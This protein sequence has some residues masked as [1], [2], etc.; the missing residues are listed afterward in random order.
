MMW[1]PFAEA[2]GYRISDQG[3]VMSPR[4]K[5]LRQQYHDGRLRVWI[6]GKRYTVWRVVLETF[7]GKPVN[8]GY[9]P[10]HLNGDLFDN[11]YENLVYA[12]AP[13]REFRERVDHC[14]M[15]HELTKEN[16]EV[17][18]TGHRICLKCR[19]GG[20]FPVTRGSTRLVT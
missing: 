14:R 17:W 1:L 19:A 4:G 9:R 8:G 16:T 3:D 11:R 5:I 6:Q 15:D 18:G 7:A 13:R 2:P 12:G 20:T 10:W